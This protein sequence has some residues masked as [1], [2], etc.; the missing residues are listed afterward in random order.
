MAQSLIGDRPELV[1]LCDWEHNGYHDSDFYMAVLNRDTGDVTREMIGTTRFAGGIDMTGY[2]QELTEEDVR[3]ALT[4]LEERIFQMI[5]RAE[6]DDV[7]APDGVEKGAAVALLSDHRNQVKHM[8]MEMCPKCNGSGQWIH[9]R[10]AE[11]VR[12]CFACNGIGEREVC[13]QAA[14]GENGKVLYACYPAGAVG[15]VIWVGTFRTVYARGY[16]KL[17]R[18]TLSTRIALADGTIINAPLA[19]LRL[20]RDPMSDEELRRRAHNLARNAKFGAAFAGGYAWDSG[21][22]V[23]EW[24]AASA[25][26]VWQ[27]P[28]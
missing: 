16:N 4:W 7:F 21:N 23:N 6:H 8:E 10:D 17:G 26:F 11:D 1:G 20:D 24:L 15:T 12:A 14:H 28:A 5:H 2:N 3:L 25:D 27:S 18:D 19:K 22:R 9:P 13:G